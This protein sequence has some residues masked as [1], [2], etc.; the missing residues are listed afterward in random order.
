M[1]ELVF[2]HNFIIKHSFIIF[3]SKKTDSKWK[4]MPTDAPLLY[5]LTPSNA[6]E[7]CINYVF[8]EIIIHNNVIIIDNSVMNLTFLCLW[9]FILF[10]Q[11]KSKLNKLKVLSYTHFVF[12]AYTII[13]AGSVFF[14]YD[15]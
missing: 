4:Y 15:T 1:I 3:T 10:V 6:R 11:C 5:Y 12:N 2:K 13:Y 9:D 8:A 7:C 14:G